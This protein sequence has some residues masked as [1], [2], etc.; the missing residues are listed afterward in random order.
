MGV[1]VSL[2][3]IVLQEHEIKHTG[4]KLKCQHC[5]KVF[6][7]PGLRRVHE[8]VLIGILIFNFFSF[9]STRSPSSALSAKPLLEGSPISLATKGS[10]GNE[11]A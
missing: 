7:R 10:L 3:V 2:D 5:P 11:F 1:M 4:E 8:Q 9:S 6:D